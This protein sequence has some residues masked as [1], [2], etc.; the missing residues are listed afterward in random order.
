MSANQEQQPKPKGPPKPLN[1]Y[2]LFFQLER[3]NILAGE[4]DQNYTAENIARIAHMHHQ[5]HRMGAPKRKHR[6][7]HGKISFVELSRTLAN[8]VSRVKG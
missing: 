2:N 5:K 8:K 4:E 6:K 3:E 1:A 7:S